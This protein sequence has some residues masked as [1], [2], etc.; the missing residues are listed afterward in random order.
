MDQND[1]EILARV[2][3]ALQVVRIEVPFLAPMT[4]DVELIPEKR[5]KT[6][7]VFASGRLV[8]NPDWM[9]KLSLSDITFIIAHEIMHLALRS[10]A[11]SSD[12]NPE[13]FNITHD[14]IINEMLKKILRRKDVPA[15]G[16]DWEKEFSGHY[17]IEDKSAEEL[18]KFVKDA[19]SE[20]TLDHN[21]FRK[22]WA[23]EPL[24]TGNT[25]LAAKLLAAMGRSK[26]NQGLVEQGTDILSEDLEKKLFPQLK[27]G[28]LSARRKKLKETS[29]EVL[30]LK[31]IFENP[32]DLSGIGDLSLS[33]RST[34]QTIKSYYQPPWE[35]ALQ[36]WLE[37]T[38]R[39]G[40]TYARP[41]RR[42]QFRDFV[43]PGFRREGHTLH[44]LLDTS[45]SMAHVFKK[46]L[47]IIANF[48]DNLMIPEIHI[49]QCDT[50]V[51]DDQWLTPEE[52]LNFEIKGLGGSNMSPGMYQ[53]A[54]DEQV[55]SAIVITD[56]YT[57]YP[58]TPM[59]YEVLWVLTDFYSHKYFQPPY[60]TIIPIENH[61]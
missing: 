11:R 41:S 53:L 24:T 47:G 33:A 46:V 14:F 48:C 4:H 57:N 23:E 26:D 60:G 22:A 15:N 59:P 52:L 17:K 58:R 18:M 20:K 43:R 45:G 40:R 56:G 49:I 25:D 39:T 36:S 30:N 12:Q 35:V 37:S 50:S 42:G 28:T 3:K 44:I 31:F 16:L 34:Y 55:D 38:Q 51:N 32:P 1:Q 21:V 9:S 6:A 10:H 2:K 54:K 8:F 29:Q 7:G 5:I 61:T 13:L 27:P 19:L